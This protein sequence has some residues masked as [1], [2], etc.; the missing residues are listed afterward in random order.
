MDIPNQEDI[1]NEITNIFSDENFNIYISNK[2]S[3]YYSVDEYIELFKCC[4]R[5]KEI[6]WINKI[7][8]ILLSIE[9]EEESGKYIQK[10]ESLREYIRQQI[11]ILRLFPCFITIIRAQS[12]YVMETI[13]YAKFDSLKDFVEAVRYNDMLGNV[14]FR[15]LKTVSFVCMMTILKNIGNILSG[16]KG[17]YL[18]WD[19][20]ISS[21]GGSRDFEKEIDRQSFEDFTEYLQEWG[22]FSSKNTPLC[23]IM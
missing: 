16:K 18:Q 23:C 15:M 4:E 19:D 12:C 3:D 7:D 6:E 8:E 1:S 10:F 11:V 22:V 17:E 2:L 5:G 9:K 21:L 13:K 14:F 20:F